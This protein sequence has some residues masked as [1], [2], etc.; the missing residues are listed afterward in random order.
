MIPSPQATEKVPTLQPRGKGQDRPFLFH[1]RE[2]YH[3]SLS[4]PFAI[5]YDQRFPLVHALRRRLAKLS[6][7]SGRISTPTVYGAG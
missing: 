6:L 7:P 1:A 5:R 4:H 3:I 2:E